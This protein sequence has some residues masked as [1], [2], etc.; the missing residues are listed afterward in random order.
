MYEGA[1]KKR[2]QLA[3]KSVVEQ[4]VAHARFVDVARLGVC[5]AE[6]IIAPVAIGFVL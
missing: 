1:I 6:M 4:S 3:V 2:I 5:Y